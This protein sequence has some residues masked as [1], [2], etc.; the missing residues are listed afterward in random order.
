MYFKILH[1]LAETTT[2]KMMNQKILV[3]MI[4]T[5]NIITVLVQKNFPNSSKARKIKFPA[6]K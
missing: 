1:T 3:N 5:Q 2:Y 6:T 4:F